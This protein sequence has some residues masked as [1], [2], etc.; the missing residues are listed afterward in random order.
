MAQDDDPIGL[1]DPYLSAVS[2]KG[3]HAHFRGGYKIWPNGAQVAR[4]DLRL[5]CIGNSTSLWPHAAWSLELGQMLASKDRI[6]A[7]YNGAGK[8]NTSSQEVLRVLR[9]APGIGPDLIICLSG[10]C[11]I[12]Y[13]LNAKGYPFRHKY[14]R[15]VMDDLVQ[16][17][18]VDDVTFGMPDLASPAEAWCRNQRMARALTEEL[19]TQMLT[20]LQ[21][22][23]G[24][25]A[26][27]Q[28]AEERAFF[29]TK[30]EVILRAA[31]KP[32]GQCVH[33]F[34]SEVLDIMARDPR[35]YRHIVDFTAV[36]DDC[37]GAFRDHRHQSPLG[38]T[39][40]AEKMLPHVRRLVDPARTT[41]ET[42]RLVLP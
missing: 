32:Y 26:Y 38:V 10:I 37:P 13:L 2:P 24:Y 11:D 39:Y 28:S 14:T 7:I 1:Y 9:D 36:F 31:D 29:K 22:V 20:F 40:L 25:G 27:P 42:E 41:P 17:E 34:Y 23:Q 3:N 12:G 8:G 15:R 6:V 4:A 5:M 19:G 33:E 18:I 21:P 35:P 30:A 16:R